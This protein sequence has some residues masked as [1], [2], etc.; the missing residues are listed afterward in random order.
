MSNVFTADYYRGEHYPEYFQTPHWLNFKEQHIYSNPRAKCYICQK[1]STLLPHHFKYRNL[2]KERV[3][4]IFLFFVFGD[5]VIVCFDCH[6]AI[7]FITVKIF[8]IKFKIKVPVKTF[9]LLA[10]MFYLRYKYCI[11]NKRY[12]LLLQSNLL[13]LKS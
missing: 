10:R 1:K 9:F 5:I 3:M 8:F 11:Q 12:G 4:V 2:F 13:Y 7:H 6:T